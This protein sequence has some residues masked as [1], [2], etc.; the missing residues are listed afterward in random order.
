[1][2]KF[3]V[4]ITMLALIFTVVACTNSGVSPE[5]KELMDEYED[6]F[7]GYCDFMKEYKKSGNSLSL[8][9]EYTSWAAKYAQM[10][11]KFEAIADRELN[12][13][14]IEYYEK[15]NARILKKL[16]SIY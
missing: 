16:S 13:A 11:Y 12:D 4:L 7:D 5:F 15:I 10:M 8:L 3:V 6:F 2:K 14:E 1:M 9:S